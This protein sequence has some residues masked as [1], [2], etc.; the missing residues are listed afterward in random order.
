[1]ECGFLVFWL[2]LVSVVEN[3][4][5][6]VRMFMDWFGEIVGLGL[7]FFFRVFDLVDLLWV[8]IWFYEDCS[9]FVVICVVFC[10]LGFFEDFVRLVLVSCLGLGRLCKDVILK[11]VK[12]VLVVMKV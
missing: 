10:M 7:V 12:K 5:G 9:I 2:W 11:V 1:M 4:N 6:L 8:V 3:Y